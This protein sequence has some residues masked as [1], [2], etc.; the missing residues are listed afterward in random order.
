MEVHFTKMLLKI[1]DDFIAVKL[2]FHQ[3]Y[4]CRVKYGFCCL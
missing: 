2:D 4:N 1:I 3:C